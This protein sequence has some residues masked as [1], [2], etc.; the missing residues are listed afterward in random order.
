MMTEFG[1]NSSYLTKD[2]QP[3]FPIMGE[4]HYSRYPQKYWKESLY[5]MKAGGVEVVS[6]YAI[7]IHHEEIE[8]EYDF[9]GNKDLRSYVNAVKDC[10]LYLLLRLG[11][12]VHGEVRNGGFPDWLMNKGY[13]L[14]HNDPAYLEEVRRYYT[15]LY[16]QVRGLLLT[17][18]GPIIGIQIE[19]ELGHC[20]G[21]YGEEGEK[22]M[23]QLKQI[24]VEA[25][26]VVPF[27][28]ATGWGGAAT[29]GLLPVMGGY[30][31]APWDQRLTEIEPSGN[32]IFTYERN[33]HNIG[34]DYGL[35]EGVSF[36]FAHF[37]YLTAELG[38]GLQV[39]HH[40]RPV[41]E[42]EDIGA[43]SLVKLGSG[44]N[45]LGYYMYHGGT[46]PMGKLS[47]LQESRATGYPNDL[48][49]LNYDF[50]APIREY[51]Q[52]SDTL[53]ELKLFA[54]F[55]KEFGSE[56]CTMS[57]YIP[58]ENPLVPQNQVDLR[59]S[60]RHN[61]QSGYLFVNNFQ[62]HYPM[63]EHKDVILTVELGEEKITFPKVTIQDKD[64]FFLPFHMKVGDAMIKTAMVSPLC[65]LNNE[66]KT[67]IF[68]GD[69]EPEFELEG[70][71][72]NTRLITLSR[73]DARNAWK[74]TLDQ[75]YLIVSEQVVLQT[76]KGI[77][78]I[79]STP[80]Q[81]KVYPE[82]LTLPKGWTKS[83]SDGEFAVYQKEQKELMVPTEV[84]T[85]VQSAE[86]RKYSIR[87]EY[88]QEM[89]DQD[90]SSARINDCFLL[91]QY[92]GDMAKAYINGEYVAD[93]YYTGRPWEIGLKRFDFVKEITIELY[94]LHEGA[95]IY[96]EEWPVMKEGVACELT[97]VAATLEYR[98]VL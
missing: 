90:N 54:M 18:G 44:V 2:N 40:R 52:V 57:A 13:Q 51:G 39:T 35:G 89:L 16:E 19:N 22:H 10:G 24:A 48:P 97:K 66:E 83:E 49:E 8:G 17:D 29:G 68:Y 4:M 55:A 50:R 86:K 11:P 34:S 64:Y 81:M 32:F 84:T 85:L 69:R 73:R 93:H 47:T 36:D 37:P 31:E 71:L 6:A 14:R 1:F 76:E 79:G 12:W 80:L 87:L 9:S 82:L 15:T 96:L 62:R 3:W 45:L 60:I 56:L 70:S 75:E 41:A 21:A 33:D 25:G 88:P 95:P 30:P 61:G 92:E 78:L 28:T 77:E 5:K 63:A 38:G 58:E 94:P 53:K 59:S 98:T 27:Y 7:W 46:N 67:Y 42:A 74:V 20:G 43:M 72:V 26:F 65:V 91:I 23:Q